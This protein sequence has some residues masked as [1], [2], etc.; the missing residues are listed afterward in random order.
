M[1]F[2]YDDLYGDAYGDASEIGFQGYREYVAGLRSNFVEQIRGRATIGRARISRAV[3]LL[4]VEADLD[5]VGVD[6]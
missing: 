1:H 6:L 5:G 3:K 4:L 2:V